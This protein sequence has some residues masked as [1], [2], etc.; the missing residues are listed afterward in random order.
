MHTNVCTYVHSQQSTLDVCECF[1][2]SLEKGSRTLSTTSSV[3]PRPGMN[4]IYSLGEWRS[5]NGNR[6]AIWTWRGNFYDFRTTL[7]SPNN[8]SL[9]LLCPGLLSFTNYSR[10]IYN[11]SCIV[12]SAN[13]FW[14]AE[15]VSC[16]EWS[17][18]E[19]RTTI[20][21][22][23]ICCSLPLPERGRDRDG[24]NNRIKRFIT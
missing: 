11:T 16:R 4:W 14:T 12:V 15:G 22:S 8:K 7:S 17:D 2:W 18:L 13:L 1:V 21:T 24:W 5:R 20:L 23:E 10:N 3:Q 9:G 19:A 6:S